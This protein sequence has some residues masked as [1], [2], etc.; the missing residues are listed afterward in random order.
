[1]TSTNALTITA[2]YDVAS[3]P[4]VPYAYHVTGIFSTEAERDAALARFPKNLNLRPSTLGSLDGDDQY[5]IVGTGKFKEQKGNKFNETAQRRF[6]RLLDLIDYK[7][8]HGTY[9]TAE[10]ARAACL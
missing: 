1:M 10:Q 9:A 4:A 5:T 7:A 8:G 6:A 2:S 3:G